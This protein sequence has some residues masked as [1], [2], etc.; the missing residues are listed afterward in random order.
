MTDRRGA[1]PH[2]AR[3]VAALAAA[4]LLAAVLACGCA[5]IP[6]SGI[7][8]AAAVP[9]PQGGDVAQCCGV[10][11]EPP[12]VGWSPSEV[13]TNFLLASSNAANNYRAA[14]AYLMRPALT[15]WHPGPGVTILSEA[16]TVSPARPLNGP[17]GS[18]QVEVTGNELATLSSSGQY[19]QAANGAQVSP[20]AF[21]LQLDHGVYKISNLPPAGSGPASGLLLTSDLFH[22]VY[23]PRNLYYYGAG[24]GTGTLLPDPVYVPIQSA[25]LVSTLVN[26]LRHDPGGWLT[27]AAK[28]YLPARA[29]LAGVQVFPGP[30]GGKTAI[31]NVTLPHGTRA[32]I[33]DMV[34]QLVC[35]LTNG[36]FSQQLFR[37][38]RIKIN[39]RLWPARGPAQN[40]ASYQGLIPH[41]RG[42]M[43]VYYLTPGGTIKTLRATRS[44][45]L[46][47]GASTGEPSLSQVAVSP[48]GTHLAGIAG[49][50]DTVYTGSLGSSAKPG[51]LHAQLTGSFSA[52]SWD[53]MD[54]LWVV[55][56]VSRSP[57][58]PLRSRQG[59]FVLQGGQGTLLPVSHP[60]FPGSVTGLRVAPD[61]ARVAMII[62][63][64]PK[65]QVWLAAARRGPTGGF[66]ITQPVPLGGQGLTGVLTGV[67]ALTWYDEDHLLVVTKSGSGTQLWEV[68]V[69]GVSPVS[70]GSES[71]ITSVT[72]AG[73]DNPFYLGITGRRLVRVAG[74]DHFS[75][76]ITA[77]QA[78]AYPG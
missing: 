22:H 19:I 15:S 64:G 17:Q 55:G 62:G 45:A 37:A 58:I 71:G 14:R 42:G 41:W 6:S 5:A 38:V 43:E 33:P 21:G 28:T 63:S 1:V 54:D 78:P 51:L 66:S 75:Q 10:Q 16:P 4:V 18:S 49:P 44:A 39:G 29:R 53:R 74:L 8:Q 68:P 47:K 56:R 7:P 69:D 20:E 52:L 27:G 34:A 3:G 2:P 48:D 59:I 77:G 46:A 40:L 60:P 57:D 30:S 72:A 61:G 26:D 73:P 13:V 9:A 76:E 12:Q 36:V 25:D 32:N 31:V 23:T 24:P 70:L 50:A 65:T 67:T 35:T 11:V